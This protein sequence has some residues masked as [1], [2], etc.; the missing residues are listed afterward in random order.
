MLTFRSYLAETDDMPS[1]RALH[2]LTNTVFDIHGLRT[3]PSYEY[4]VVGADKEFVSLARNDGA[5]YPMPIHIK[6]TDFVR[7]QHTGHIAPSDAPFV[8]RAEL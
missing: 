5:R 8:P 2:A 1:T 3:A 4:Y 7:Y 6:T